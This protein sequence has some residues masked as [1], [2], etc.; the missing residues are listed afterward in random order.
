[1]CLQTA[2]LA[3]KFSLKSFSNLLKPFALLLKT[4]YNET[5]EVVHQL[6]FNTYKHL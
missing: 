2:L 4:F 3:K 6:K 1:M 5:P